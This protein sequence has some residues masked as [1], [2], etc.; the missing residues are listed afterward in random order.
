MATI[1][2]APLTTLLS[3]G[4]LP[5]GED[6][7]IA[8]NL[9]P[10]QV[11]DNLKKDCI[12]FYTPDT[13]AL[14]RKIAMTSSN[15]VELGKIRWRCA[16]GGR[17]APA[18]GCPARRTDECRHRGRAS[19]CLHPGRRAA[20]A[21]GCRRT[22]A[23]GFPDLFVEDAMRVRNRHVAFLAPF[24]TPSVIFEQISIIYA[25]PRLFV[26][27]FTLVLPF[28]PTGTLERVSSRPA[29]GWP[30]GTGQSP[31]AHAGTRCCCCS[32]PAAR[33]RAAGRAPPPSLQACQ[34]RRRRSA[35]PRP[36]GPP[37]SA[38]RSHL[39]AAHSPQTTP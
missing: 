11:P 27:S 23:D 24:H 38:P 12:L 1:A 15:K 37:G 9:D 28:F 39:P 30:A 17:P 13:E 19:T 34:E 33:R 32:A 21:P 16:A 36:S 18:S 26:G 3:S 31:P 10:S 6:F 22:F 29:V 7:R 14:A 4:S 25:L 5:S 35:W 20:P 8:G 2:G